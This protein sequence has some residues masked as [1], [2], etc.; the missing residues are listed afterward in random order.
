MI[1][2]AA[3]AN[4]DLREGVVTG[5][6]IGACVQQDGYDIARLSDGV[7]YYDNDINLD[8][9]SLPVPSPVNP[10]AGRR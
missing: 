6:P 3:G 9:T 4:L 7:E 2:D 10:V 1:V 5:S 8:S